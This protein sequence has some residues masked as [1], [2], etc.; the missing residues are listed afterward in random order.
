[1]IT[2]DIINAIWIRAGKRE[3][4]QTEV[5][6]MSTFLGMTQNISLEDYLTFLERMKQAA[7]CDMDTFPE[8]EERSGDEHIFSF[9]G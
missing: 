6:K 5:R 4:I 9:L 2:A 8:K 1:M 3:I 7:F